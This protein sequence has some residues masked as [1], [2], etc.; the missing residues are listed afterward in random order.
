MSVPFLGELCVAGAS[1]AA[2]YVLRSGEQKKEQGNYYFD[3]NFWPT[4][5]LNFSHSLHR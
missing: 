2:F 5:C 4:A 1:T 3:D